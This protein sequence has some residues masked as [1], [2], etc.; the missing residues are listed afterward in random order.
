MLSL[1][2]R[3]ETA[4]DSTGHVT[5]G[6]ASTSNVGPI[7]HLLHSI[8]NQIDVYFNQKLVSPPNNA[9]AY[10]A[11]IKALLNYSP[12]KTF[13]LTSCLWDAD[14][15]GRMDE[16]TC[17]LHSRRTDARSYRSSPCCCDVFNQDKFLING[18]EVCLRLVR[19]KDSFCLMD[20]NGTSLKIHILDASLLVRKAKI[21]AGLLLAHARML[22]KVTAISAHEGRG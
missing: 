19:S 13:H 4:G 12:A 3:V 16:P 21:S 8:F 18:V 15:P 1:R 7:N 10:R 17:S 20:S 22:S 14:T 9:Y 6:S 2:V 5:G 11:Y